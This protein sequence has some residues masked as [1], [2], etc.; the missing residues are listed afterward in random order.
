MPRKTFRTAIALLFA[1]TL[2][3][4]HTAEARNAGPRLTSKAYYK[5]AKLLKARGNRQYRLY[6]RGGTH[7]ATHKLRAAKNHTKAK[8]FQLKA[9]AKK[10]LRKGDKAKADKL[11]RKAQTLE[12]TIKP[13]ATKT[14]T[15]TAGKRK[16][17]SGT[18]IP[19]AEQPAAATAQPNTAKRSASYGRLKRHLTNKD[20]SSAMQVLD[21]MEHEAGQA[22]GIKGIWKRFQAGRARRAVRRRAVD[23]GREAIRTGGAAGDQQLLEQRREYAKQVR[24]LRSAGMTPDQRQALRAELAQVPNLRTHGSN[25]AQARAVLRHLNTKGQKYEK[26]PVRRIIARLGSMVF[27]SVRSANAKL[28]H[29]L[30]SEARHLMAQGP[31]GAMQ[32]RLLLLN[33]KGRGQG[34][35]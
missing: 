32:A 26:K 10:A 4:A 12:A 9:R 8:I 18:Q 5:K 20:L 19:D 17:T 15:A 13:L 16:A 11:W 25:Y 7:A 35:T 3:G 28:D 27:G 23:I 21:A 22:H 6:K 2:I 30:I 34:K 33:A 31:D 1:A 24:A 29:A 14:K